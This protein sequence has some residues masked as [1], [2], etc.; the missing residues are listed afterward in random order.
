M[1]L[2][3]LDPYPLGCPLGI[4][5]TPAEMQR[6]VPVICLKLGDIAFATVHVVNPSKGE[7]YPMLNLLSDRRDDRPRLVLF[8]AWEDKRRRRRI[9]WRRQDTLMRRIHDAGVEA[10]ALDFSDEEGDDGKPFEASLA[11]TAVEMD[12]H[13]QDLNA[14]L[15]D[16]ARITVTQLERHRAPDLKVVKIYAPNSETT[17]RLVLYPGWTGAAE[18]ED[19]AIDEEK[20]VG[21]RLEARRAREMPIEL[22][23]K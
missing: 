21:L 22:Y 9:D 6:A 19:Q 12:N 15:G 14:Y 23:L 2:P 8:P 17:P 16:I 13:I 20:R 5:L 3:T 10:E 11:C 7:A 4:T 1:T 18:S